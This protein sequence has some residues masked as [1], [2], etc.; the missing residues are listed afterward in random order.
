VGL[1]VVNCRKSSPYTT[2]SVS[3]ALVRT[4]LLPVTLTFCW[5]L[6]VIGVFRRDGRMLHDLVARTGMIYLWDAKLAKL[7]RKV[8]REEQNTSSSSAMSIDDDS[9]ALDAYMDTTSTVE[10]NSDEERGILDHQAVSGQESNVADTAT[11]STFQS[12]E[13]R[14]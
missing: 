6:G 2:V 10:D 5:P 4:C 14:D 1:R 8:Q 7:R 12:S 3:Q 9:D 13:H 11:Y